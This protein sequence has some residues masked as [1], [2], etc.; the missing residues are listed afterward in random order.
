VNLRPLAT[1]LSLALLAPGAALAQQQAPGTP[2]PAPAPAPA[3]RIEVLVLEATT[4]SGGVAPS[5]AS[6][7]QLRQP[8]FSAYS[9]ITVLSR[10]TL[11]LSSTPANTTLPNNSSAGVALTRRTADG[12]YAVGV[13]FTQGGHA[14]RIEFVA[15]AGEPFFT[16]RSSRPERALILG[17]I[18][19]P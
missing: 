10:A 19:R 3:A 12:R 8:P 2:A 13:T 1:A 17:F 11:A 14:S 7:P 9:Q 18:V 5:L 6:L 15:G 16:V 4:G